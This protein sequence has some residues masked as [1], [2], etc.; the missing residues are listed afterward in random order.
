MNL[1]NFYTMEPRFEM[2]SLSHLIALSLTIISAIILYRI[3]NR[4]NENLAL[5][6]LI[7]YCLV[8]LLLAGEILLEYW[9]I[10]TGNWKIEYALPLQLC[11]FSILMSIIMLIRGSYG[12]FEIVYFTGIGGALV[13]IISPEL[14]LGFPHFRFYHFF[15][16][17]AAI[18]LASLYMVFIKGFRPRLIS[19]SKM[20]IFINVFGGFVFMM[21]YW[22]D[23]NYMFI[24]KPTYNN[25]FLNHLGHYPWYLLSLEG[26]IV[27]VS[28]LLY[29]PFVKNENK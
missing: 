14:W 8:T 18:I 6:K 27:F 16:S 24:S 15:I 20:L 26:I 10:I 11:D 7:R 25:T 3:R 28:F 2:F 13:A 12:I 9:Y 1:F 19:I 5:E 17:H 4:I 29:I 21:N 23:A 22:I